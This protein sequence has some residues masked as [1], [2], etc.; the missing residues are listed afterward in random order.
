MY[1]EA[2]KGALDLL[3][4]K[5]SGYITF[6]SHADRDLMNGLARLGTEREQVPYVNLVDELQKDWEDEWGADGFNEI[7]NA[8]DGH[9]IPYEVCERIQKPD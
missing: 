1:A 2:Y 6:V 7:A 5:S 3:D 8:E 4:K 9:V